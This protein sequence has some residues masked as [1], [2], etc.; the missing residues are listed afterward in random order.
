MKGI[1]GWGYRPYRPALAQKETQLP[2]VVRIAPFEDGFEAEFLDNG[3]PG[4]A[5]LVRWRPRGSEQPFETADITGSVF[6]VGGLAENA[7]Y[8]FRV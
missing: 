1:T 5:H 8:E 3:A 7:E 2:F 4:A 6:T